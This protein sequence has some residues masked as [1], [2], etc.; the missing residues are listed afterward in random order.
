MPGY[1]NKVLEI[2]LS[3]KEIK[4]LAV[5]DEEYK[6]FVGGSGMGAKLLF[7]RFDPEVDPLSPENPLIVMTGPLTGS[8]FP[9]AVTRFSVVSRAPLNGLFGESSCGGNFGVQLKRCGFDGIIVTGASDKPVYVE[10]GDNSCEIKDAADLWGKD[11]YETMEVLDKRMVDAGKKGS[12][13]FCIGPA[14]ENLVK[15]ANIMN[16]DGNT[17]G[18]TGMGAVMG[19]KKLKAFVARGSLK[20]NFADPE[21]MDET[22]KTVLLKIKESMTVESMTA[23]GTASSVDLGAMTGDLPIKNWSLGTWDEGVEKLSGPYMADTILTK[24]TACFGCN[25][26]CKRV[27]KIDSGPNA[28]TESAG[29]EYETIGSFGTMLMMPDIEFVAKCNEICNRLGMD[30]IT[31]GSTIAFLT[32]AMEHGV[33]TPDEV[34]GLSFNWGE[35]EPVKAVLKLIAYREGGGDLIAEGTRGIINKLGKGDEFASDVKGLEAP[36]HDPRPY[37]GMG[38][39]YAVGSRGAC[40]V[41]TSQMYVEHGMAFYPEMGLGDE[42]IQYENDGKAFLTMQTQ[43]LGA[44]MNSFCM[45]HFP[46]IPLAEEDHLNMINST[47]GFGYDL[48]TLLAA[49]DRAW[50]LKRGINNMF[51][52]GR[53]RDGLPIKLLTPVEDGAAAGMAPDIDALMDDFYKLRDID[54]NGK[55]SRDTLEKIGLKELADILHKQ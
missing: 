46:S 48:E 47:T 11:T 45:C 1:W 8:R 13:V 29:P 10:I 55:P 7:D 17:A 19:G 9:G 28:V 34:G 54:E 20:P 35:Q 44:L 25:V 33:I 15:F 52:A 22:R 30:T 16:G 36:M 14:G 24:N 12:A 49:G 42:V 6:K 31:C 53:E 21:K 23:F 50:L 43:K 5:S 2:D 51:G 26:A 37:W 39:N 4:E 18:R 41:N 38:L 40:H 27:V 3:K 32:D